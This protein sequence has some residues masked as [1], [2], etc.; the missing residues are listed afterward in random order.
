MILTL[1]EPHISIRVHPHAPLPVVLIVAMPLTHFLTLN[2]LGQHANL[3]LRLRI[4]VLPQHHLV[5][6]AILRFIGLDESFQF[7]LGNTQ[8]FNVAYQLT[9]IHIRHIPV[10]IHECAFPKLIFFEILLSVL[11]A[12]TIDCQFFCS[13]TEMK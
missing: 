11:I 1:G 2:L 5:G 6:N 3:T 12:G 10:D 7:L 4:Q 13:H 9:G 8:Y